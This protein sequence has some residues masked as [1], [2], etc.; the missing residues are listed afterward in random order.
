M[1]YPGRESTEERERDDDPGVRLR[2]RP[3]GLASGYR[4]GSTGRGGTAGG[5]FMA[6][7]AGTRREGEEQNCRPLVS[8]LVLGTRALLLPCLSKMRGAAK[9]QR[10]RCHGMRFAA[11]T[12]AM[13]P[14]LAGFGQTLP[15]WPSLLAVTL[16]VC[17]SQKAAGHTVPVGLVIEAGPVFC[18]SSC[19]DES[20]KKRRDSPGF[21]GA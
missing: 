19:L 7:A 20:S 9:T 13:S 11:L 18:P 16:S 12:L 6:K 17:R 14:G 21:G 3:D 8:H 2:T 4:W 5:P 1:K 10:K 15:L